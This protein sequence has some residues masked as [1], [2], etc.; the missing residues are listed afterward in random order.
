MK[1][2]LFYYLHYSN[3]YYS[4]YSRTTAPGSIWIVIFYIDDII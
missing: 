1:N 2:Y 4:I 3:H